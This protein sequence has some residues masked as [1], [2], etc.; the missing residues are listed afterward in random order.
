VGEGGAAAWRGEDT[1]IT[2]GSIK[3]DKRMEKDIPYRPVILIVLAALE[4]IEQAMTGQQA[5]VSEGRSDGE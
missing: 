3:V 2:I 4:A 5:A 1:K